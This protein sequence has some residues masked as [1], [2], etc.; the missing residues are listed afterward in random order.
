ME[1]RRNFWKDVLVVLAGAESFLRWRVLQ[2]RLLLDEWE[3]SDSRIGF[4]PKSNF[5]YKG[6]PV[7]NSLG[8]RGPEFSPE[9][10]PRVF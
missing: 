5:A 3:I 7:T 10:R 2:K 1:G 4:K 6:I 9:K 8:F